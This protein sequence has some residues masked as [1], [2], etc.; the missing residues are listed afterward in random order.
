MEER[1]LTNFQPSKVH[2]VN[3]GGIQF[4]DAYRFEW[5]LEPLRQNGLVNYTMTIG[6]ISSTLHIQKYGS[7]AQKASLT[8]NQ[9]KMDIPAKSVIASKVKLAIE[10]RG[11]VFRLLLDDREMLIARLL[12][13]RPGTGAT[14]SVWHEQGQESATHFKL[15]RVSGTAIVGE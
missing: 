1:Y 5:V 13:H 8:L 2:K 4:P 10:K 3:I 12:R 15:L 9:S 11:S 14:F 6:D 7:W